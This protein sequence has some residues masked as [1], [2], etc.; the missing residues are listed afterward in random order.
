VVFFPN[1]LREGPLTA[2]FWSAGAQDAEL[3]IYNLQGEVVYK[4][5]LQVQDGLNAHAVDLDVASGLYV[6][7]L[8]WERDAGRMT[9][10]AK[11]IAVTR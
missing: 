9:S 5:P 1:P 3:A 2:R 7:R 11:T 8:T 6:A 10:Q 4:T